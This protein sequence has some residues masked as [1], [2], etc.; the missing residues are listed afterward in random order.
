MSYTFKIYKSSSEILHNW[1]DVIGQHNIMLSKE[2]FETLETS[3]PENMKCFYVG[4]FS[5]DELIGGSLF[6]YLDFFRHKTFQQDEA[7]CNLKNFVAKK[8]SKNVMIL[9]NNMLTGQNGFYFDAEKITIPDMILL[10]DEAVHE[11]QKKEGKTSL[12]IYKDYQ[13]GFIEHF[14]DKKYQSFY[15]FSVQPNMLLDLKENWTTFEDYLNAFSTKYRTRAKSAKKKIAGIEKSEMS[16]DDIKFHQKEM[17]LLYQNVAENAPFNTFFLTENHFESM[18]ESLED[19]F[20]VFGYYLN[21]KLIGFYTLIL[22]NNDIDT[23][24]LGYDK[25]LQKEKQIY[26]NMLLDMVEFGIKEKF[27][28]IIFGRTALEIKS[29]IGAQP[30]EIFGLI[31]H[32]NWLINKFI[33]RIFKSLNPTVD[34]IQRKPFK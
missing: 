15:R 13:A 34:W 26:L 18:K 33:G 4:F 7:F 24:F 14:Q 27:N 19:N 23:Y 20:K 2:Y 29:T 9:G 1:N 21:E 12:I 11:M 10:L 6:Q 3:C 17:N 31:K 32:N 30:V 16:L 5:G 8:F 25:E 22:N 28:R